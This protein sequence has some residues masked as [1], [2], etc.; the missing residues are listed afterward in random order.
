MKVKVF[1]D[2]DVICLDHFSGIGH[3][4]AA[5]LKEVDEMLDSDEFKHIQITLGVPWRHKHRLARFGFKNFAVRRMPVTH[6]VSNKLKDL[7]LLPPIDLLFGK[8]V[9]VFPHFSSWPTMS[10]PSIPIIYDLS[11]VLHPEFSAD[12]NRIFLT[13][14]AQLAVERATK[15][16]TISR[17][18]KQEIIEHYG[19]S[20]SDIEILYPII[21]KGAF[22]KRTKEE[23]NDARAKYGVFG[24]YILFVGN[25][26]PRKNLISLLK[27]YELLDEK[28]FQDYSLLLVGAKGWKDDEIHSLISKLQSK[29][30]KVIQPTSYVT[31]EDLPALLSGATAFAYVSRYEGFG[32]PPV[33]AMFCGTPVVSSNNSSLPEAVGDAALMVDAQ[34]IPQIKGGLVQILTDPSLRKSLIQK[35]FK[36]IEK[37]MFKPELMARNFLELVEQTHERKSNVKKG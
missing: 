3:Y 32:I 9:Y 17:N 6:R 20:G 26:E 28:E 8:Q 19:K 24:K 1:V 12:K 13:K 25:I 11:F 35:G 31:D 34:N 10:S 4:T 2:A 7:R 5:L 14:Q 37:S 30:R 27:A 18:S 33:E 22:Y 15:I 36:H 29:N 21:K 16:I 23:V